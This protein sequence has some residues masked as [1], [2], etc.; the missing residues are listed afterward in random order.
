[1]AEWSLQDAKNR[2]SELAKV[3]LAGEPQQVNRYG[4]PAVVAMAV[5]EY[6]RLRRLAKSQ[7]PSLAELMLEK[8]Q[9]DQKFERL[10]VGSRSPDLG[11]FFQP[12][13]ASKLVGLPYESLP[14]M[15]SRSSLNTS[16][17]SRNALAK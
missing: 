8:P 10:S 17:V 12:R 4:K 7:T 6:D 3:A 1:M 2:C 11:C 15:S 14:K 5:E 9:E 13:K 16:L